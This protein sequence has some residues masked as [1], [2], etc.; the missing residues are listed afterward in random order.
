MH[1]RRTPKR[2]SVLRIDPKGPNGAECTLHGKYPS[3]GWKWHGGTVGVD[4]AIYGIPA[5]ANTI[6]KI[7]LGI[8]RRW[9][10]LAEPSHRRHRTDGKYKFL[11]G[12]LGKDGCVYFIPSDSDYVLQVDCETDEVREVGESLE[13]ERTT[14][15]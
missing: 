7:V 6:L 5:H 15:E 10:R 11:G 13:N 2:R 3:G 1:L 12:V 8:P 4:G 14:A 9:W